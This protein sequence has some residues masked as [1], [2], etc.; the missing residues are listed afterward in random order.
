MMR[1][2]KKGIEILKQ[3]GFNGTVFIPEFQDG[4]AFENY[5]QQIQGISILKFRHFLSPLTP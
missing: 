1:R 2:Y 3:I 5:D 4:R